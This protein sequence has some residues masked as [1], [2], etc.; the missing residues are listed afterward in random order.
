MYCD[1]TMHIE[2]PE[3]ESAPCF[4]TAAINVYRVY[5]VIFIS[6]F[7]LTSNIQEQT[8]SPLHQKPL[9]NIMENHLVYRTLVDY[10][11]REDE[12][13]FNELGL[14]TN[15]MKAYLYTIAILHDTVLCLT[16][17]Q[18]VIYNSGQKAAPR[19]AMYL[20]RFER[21]TRVV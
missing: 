14:H 8:N 15:P 12:D 6:V 20:R 13:C 4:L 19:T 5:K 10:Y 1:A 18:H 7:V 17:Q 3:V 21:Q 11:R 16:C 9:Y 2:R